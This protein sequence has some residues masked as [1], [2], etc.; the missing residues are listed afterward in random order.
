MRLSKW[1]YVQIGGWLLALAAMAVA[2]VWVDRNDW[3]DP[4]VLGQ[5]L[6]PYR[7][8]WLGLPL[9][10]GVFVLAELFFFPVLVLIF[11][12]GLA[13]GP[14]LGAIYALAGA[15]ASAV[16]P[17][18][19][20]RWLGRKR[21]MQWGGAPARKLAKMLERKG[22]VAVFLVRKIPA[23]YTAVN[24]ICGASGIG[25]GEFLLGTAL[26]MVTG[27]VLIVVVGTNLTQ[28]IADPQPSQVAVAAG[29]IAGVALLVYIMQRFLNR[30]LARRVERQQ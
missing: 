26:G 20:G 23:P 22:V 17:F 10:L 21:L 25:L 4:E 27:I 29:L 12:S 15:V 30:R 5:A 24:M 13:F 16:L 7:T 9:A 28:I 14:W 3:T 2:W 1:H 8:S 6:E 19:V 11:M 18:F